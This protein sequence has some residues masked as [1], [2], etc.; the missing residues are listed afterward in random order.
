MR[1]WSSGGDEI[2]REKREGGIPRHS[3]VYF[4]S[5]GLVFG[6]VYI[7]L[8][9]TWNVSYLLNSISNFG[10]LIISLPRERN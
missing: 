9:F 5:N 1:E 4:T 2:R 10:L 7:I 8:H 6:F 3:F